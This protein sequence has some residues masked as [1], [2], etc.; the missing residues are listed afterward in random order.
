MN[1]HYDVIVLGLGAMGSAALYQLSK[2]GQKILGIDMFSPPHSFGS[3]FG[4]SR[5]TRQA[6]GEG[7]FYTPMVLRANVI[8]KEIEELSGEELYNHCGMLIAAYEEQNFL[9]NTVKAAKDF[10]IE[11]Q[12]LHGSDVEKLFPA[13]KTAS[14]D[15]VFYYEPTAG[16]LRPEKCIELQLHIARRNGAEIQINTEVISIDETENGITLH[17]A[18]GNRLRTKKLVVTS[19]PW[20]K[21]M[22]SEVLKPVLKTYLQT[23]YWFDIDRDFYQEVS[24]DKMP[25]FLC[26]VEQASTTRSF[27]GFPA[28]DGAAGGLKFAMHET[29]VEIDPNQKDNVKPLST[30]EEL[31]EY[32][33]RY[34]KHIKPEVLRTFNCVYTTTPDENFIIDF[35]PKSE[36]IVFASACSGHGFKHAAAVGEILSEMVTD[37]KSKLDI[38]EFRL[39]RFNTT[40]I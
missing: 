19:G 18:E 38:H 9:K 14:T 12:I 7:T 17:L 29:N 30:G 24:P 21:D 13:F 5:V 37:G 15:H 25:V 34:I 4:E 16:F 40:K 33:S 3:S 39:N 1:N 35:A 32:V 11:H 6:I 2:T 8:W 27:Y 26:G 36:R 10:S 31:Y 28:I 20:I 23:L 22:L